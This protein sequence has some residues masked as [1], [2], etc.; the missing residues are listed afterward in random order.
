MFASPKCLSSLILL[1]PLAYCVEP[2]AQTYPTTVEVDLVFPR[3][4]TY[5][6][7]QLMPMIFALQNPQA[8]V[9][10]HLNIAWT[11]GRV[12]GDQGAGDSANYTRLLQD[13]DNFSQANLSTNDPYFIIRYTEKLNNTEGHFWLAWGADNDNCSRAANGD[14]GRGWDSSYNIT[15]F[16]TKNGAQ[17]PS[18]V[19][20]PDTCPLAQGFTYNVTGTMKLSP[21]SR[22]VCPI[23]ANPPP[24]ATPCALNISDSQASIIMANI[25]A[26]A[27]FWAQSSFPTLAICS[28]DAN[29]TVRVAAGVREGEW[30][31]VA[32]SL[33]IGTILGAFLL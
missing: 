22:G 18:L 26:D 3:N 6:P 33:L 9:R 23:T 7:A 4:E 25:T 16:T 27:C 14:V 10:L 32:L 12:E 5:A 17:Q 31:K 28:S 1:L 8:A 24:P 15:Y 30:D 29:R 20:R 11:L 13:S 2:A 21:A 19:T